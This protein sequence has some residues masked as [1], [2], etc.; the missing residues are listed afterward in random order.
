MHWVVIDDPMQRGSAIEITRIGR[1][2]S[3]RSDPAFWIP[4]FPRA[5]V[6]RVTPDR[7]LAFYGIYRLGVCVLSQLAPQSPPT[8]Q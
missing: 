3:I 8:K 2:V 5:F 1:T 7:V 4:P 6:G